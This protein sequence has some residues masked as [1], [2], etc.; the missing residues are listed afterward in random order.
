MLDMTNSNYQGEIGFL[1]NSRGKKEYVENAGDLL[2]CL[3]S[4]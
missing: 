1:L 4:D 2:E 3:Y